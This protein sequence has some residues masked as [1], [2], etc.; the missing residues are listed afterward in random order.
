MRP[1]SLLLALVVLVA[2]THDTAAQAN[3]AFTPIHNA[4]LV[5]G[6]TLH[7]AIDSVAG[8]FVVSTPLTVSHAQP[9]TSHITIDFGNNIYKFNV[10]VGSG[11]LHILNDIEKLTIVGGTFVNTNAC[12]LAGPGVVREIVMENAPFT[13]DANLLCRPV[14]KFT[15]DSQTVFSSLGDANGL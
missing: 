2:C 10:P 9:T 15:T 1:V 11:M 4:Q 7:S 13:T 8:T 3:G 6:S 14:S 5:V 12:I